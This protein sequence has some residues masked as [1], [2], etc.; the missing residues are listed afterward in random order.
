M[1]S[2]VILHG[3]DQAQQVQADEVKSG[4]EAEG[5]SAQL[6]SLDQARN[7]S[8]GPD[9]VVI[10]LLEL[11]DPVW[12]NISPEL[13]DILQ[14]LLTCS[15]RLIWVSR[16][17]GFR[18]PDPNHHI[19]DGLLRVLHSE[20]MGATLISL[21]LEADGCI[22]SHRREF[23]LQ[24]ARLIV[25]S[26]G[27]DTEY[28]EDQGLLHIPRLTS[29][30]R[31]NITLH[32]HQVGN[33][34]RQATLGD[35][36]PLRLNI[37]TPGLLNSLHFV[38][39]N[40]GRSAELKPYD[41]EIHVMSAG[42]SF[43]DVLIAQGRLNQRTAGTECAGIVTRCGEHCEDLVVGTRVAAVCL[44]SFKSFARVDCRSAVRIPDSMP[45]STAA[46]IP[47]NFAT[48]WYSLKE[49]ARLSPTETVLIHSGAGA[50]G[51][52]AIQVALHLGAV[53]FTTVSTEKKKQFLMDRYRIPAGHI[54]SSCEIAF[55]SGIKRLTQGAGADVI[56]NSL[57]GE[58]LAASWE[59]IAPYGRFIELGKKDITSHS[60]LTMS[61]FEKNVTLRAV[62]IPAMSLE[63]PQVVRNAMEDVLPLVESGFLQPAEPLQVYGVSEMENSFRTMQ[64]RNSMGKVVVEF[65]PDDTV[66]VSCIP[67]WLKQ[68]LIASRLF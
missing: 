12:L 2:L 13:F 24:L 43:R 60:K 54:F 33:Q 1:I 44:D 10:S 64:S 32:E 46:A 34:R 35:G 56:L 55:C 25:I 40:V 58:G 50:T 5:L 68:L 28:V 27:I 8:P 3:P 52:A 15:P 38:E 65:R 48:S 6:A 41:I 63:R 29:A 23:I 37:G 51:Q 47:F 61:S 26:E 31:M 57:S 59:C 4:A 39:D 14:K 67:G 36:I 7:I 18:S 16:G 9:T 11:H 20:L 21:A 49:V 22:N 17:G 53:V 42:V 66:N 62:D 45:F 19:V 30:N